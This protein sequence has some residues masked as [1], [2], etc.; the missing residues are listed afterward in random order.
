LVEGETSDREVTPALVHAY[1]KALGIIIRP[2]PP[3]NGDDR[4]ALPD[5]LP[6]AMALSDVVARSQKREWAELSRTLRMQGET[7]S[8][9]SVTYS[10]IYRITASTTTPIEI[11][12]R[13]TRYRFRQ[14]NMWRSQAD[15]PR[16]HPRR[17]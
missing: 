8:A 3:G 10:S 16:M 12:G 11:L 14:A 6:D 2:R 1:Q 7:W 9:P 13:P 15:R 4:A 5:E 17:I